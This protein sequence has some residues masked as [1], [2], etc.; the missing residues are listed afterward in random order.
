[1]AWG[2][3]ASDDADGCGSLPPDLGSGHVAFADSRLR[4]HVVRPTGCFP[5]SVSQSG[6]LFTWPAWSP[7]A[8]GVAYAG[9]R[10]AIGA[11]SPL[12]LWMRSPGERSASR[13]FTSRPGIGP[14]LPGMPYYPLWSPDASR[15]SLMAG[16]PTG[17]TLYLIDPDDPEGVEAA[18]VGSPMYADWSAD[19]SRMLLH[20]GS[21]HLLVDARGKP[22]AEDLDVQSLGYRAPAWWP[23]GN[24][25]AML[26]EEADGSEALVMLDTETRRTTRVADAEAETAFLWS[27]DGRMLAAASSDVPGSFFYRDLRFYSPEGVELPLAVTEGVAAF[28]W[29]PDSSKLAYVTLTQPSNALRWVALDVETGGTWPVADFTPTSEQLLLFRFFDQFAK[30]HSV[31]SPDSRSLVFAGTLV[32]QTTQAS[33]RSQQGPRIMVADIGPAPVV[34]PIADGILAVWSPR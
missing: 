11:P 26:A 6:G 10:L 34:R 14:I 25:A 8:S 30:S 24:R 23:L 29:S 31:W 2:A 9:Q 21:R 12:E 16:A 27:P 13:L 33:L 32:S 17:L 1:M 18:A 20:V 15:L 22:S 3:S 4:V 19:S 7:D 28:F 5:M